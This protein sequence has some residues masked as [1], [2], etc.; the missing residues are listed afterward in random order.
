MLGQVGVG[1][2]AGRFDFQVRYEQ[3]LTPYSRRFTYAGNTHGYRQEIRQGLF[4]AGFL[5]QNRPRPA[6]KR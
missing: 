6:A 1:F 4:T 2:V 3:S 5:L